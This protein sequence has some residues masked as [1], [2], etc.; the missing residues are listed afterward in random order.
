[1]SGFDLSVMQ[2]DYWN[3][4][5]HRWNIKTGATGSGKTYLDFYLLPKRIRACNGKGLI[6]LLGNTKTTLER[7]I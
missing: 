5:T 3:N 7:N 1:M 4:S 2:K 6:V